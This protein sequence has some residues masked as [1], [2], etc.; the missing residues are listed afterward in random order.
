M[1]PEIAPISPHIAQHRNRPLAPKNN[2]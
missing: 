2:S 1:A